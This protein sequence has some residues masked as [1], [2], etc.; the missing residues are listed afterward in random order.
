MWN[1]FHSI[2]HMATID[3]TNH[4]TRMAD[5]HDQPNIHHK[6]HILHN[7]LRLYCLELVTVCALGFIDCHFISLAQPVGLRCRRLIK[8]INMTNMVMSAR[9]EL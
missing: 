4:K 2:L 5:R 9:M 1:L 8:Q 7:F 6:L 3:E